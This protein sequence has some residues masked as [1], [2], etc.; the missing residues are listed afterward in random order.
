MALYRA[1]GV[2]P[3][4]GTR[5]DGAVW[6]GAGSGATIRGWVYPTMSQSERFS[7]FNA[8][9]RICEEQWDALSPEDRHTWSKYESDARAWSSILCWI[10]KY[11]YFGAGGDI[12]L[13]FA[14]NVLWRAAQGLAP[15]SVAPE[16]GTR[17]DGDVIA[18]NTC[19]PPP[20]LP[21]NFREHCTLEWQRSAGAG[22]G[23]WYA[24]VFGRAVNTR[25]QSNGSW[26][27]DRWGGLVG[28][29]PNVPLVVDA[30]LAASGAVGTG[31][32][33]WVRVCIGEIGQAPF[34]SAGG[35][36]DNGLPVGAG[37]GLEG[38]GG[39]GWGES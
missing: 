5:I 14:G 6:S 27:K 1:A 35:I 24:A 4:D 20:E 28:I 11:L 7:R 23:P 9:G 21:P 3:R 16:V 13:C 31:N 15:L 2:E 8:D 37:W 36:F 33:T 32:R 10:R 34:I 25:R 39:F 12:A 18:I 17:P 22:P 26:S 29:E 38:W 19:S 30:V